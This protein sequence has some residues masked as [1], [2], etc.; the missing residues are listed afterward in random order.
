MVF[1]TP[2]FSIHF[3]ETIENKKLNITCP[4]GVSAEFNQI[5]QYRSRRQG[6]S[7]FM[8]V[9]AEGW[10]CETSSAVSGGGKSEEVEE[11]LKKQRLHLCISRAQT[12]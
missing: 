2:T 8:N 9:H 3:L 5:A 12:F 1:D 11:H 7:T 10:D 4:R 6:V